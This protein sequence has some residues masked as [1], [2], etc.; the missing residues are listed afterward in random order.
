MRN[1]L[2]LLSI[3]LLFTS[4]AMKQD[5]LTQKKVEETILAQERKTLDRWAAG[6]PLGYAENSAEDVTWFD[7]VAAQTRIDGVVE[8]R[9]YLTSLV[10]KYP[11]H[12]YE[13]VDPKV[14][15][16]GDIAICTL[17]YNPTING[18]PDTP[19]KATDVYRLT[20]GKWR[21]VHANWTLVKEQ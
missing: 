16:Y 19:W 6:D 8:L 11:P 3:L 10:G 9:N 15:V 21:L 14:Q 4:C 2:L 1:F 13:I 12:T 20:N 18:K 7:D 17:H 5:A